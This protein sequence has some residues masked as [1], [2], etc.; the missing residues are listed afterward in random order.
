MWNGD[1]GALPVVDDGKLAGMITDRDMFIALGTRN[2]QASEVR[3]QDV[4]AG[5]PLT[6]NA[7]DDVATAMRVMRA[8]KV[9]RLPVVNAAGMLEGIVALSDIALHAV[10]K[11]RSGYEETVNTMKAI[12]EHAA[13]KPVTEETR[14]PAA[15]AVAG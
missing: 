7:E 5:A 10:S 4:I 8:A 14:K 13:R 12:C 11:G 2:L 9:R 15:M 6:C 3:V 1:C